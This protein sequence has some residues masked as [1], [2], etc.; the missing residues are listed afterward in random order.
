M[1]ADGEE[2]DVVA[3]AAGQDAVEQSVAQLFQGQVR[4]LGEDASE[5]GEALVDAGAPVLDQPVGDQ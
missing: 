3:G 4:Q 5:P 2:C 1:A